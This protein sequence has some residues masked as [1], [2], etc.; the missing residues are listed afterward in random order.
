M[1]YSSSLLIVALIAFAGWKLNVG[2]KTAREGTE[3]SGPQASAVVQPV[4][5]VEKAYWVPGVS[6][7]FEAGFQ[8]SYTGVNLRHFTFTDRK[9]SSISGQ[10]HERSVSTS[11]SFSVLHNASARKDRFA[12]AG[13]AD[14]GALIVECWTLVPVMV[15]VNLPNGGTAQAEAVDSNGMTIK[16]L[17]KLEVFRGGLGS[18]ILGFEY[19]ADGRFVLLL[20]ADQGVHRLYSIESSAGATP[21]ELFNSNLVAGLEN[22]KHLAVFGH[23]VVNRI[24]CFENELVNSTSA[25][26]FVDGDNDG[27]P[28]GGPYSGDWTYFASIGLVMDENWF[29]FHHP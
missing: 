24:W 3:A 14:G 15:T 10:W 1:K 7:W 5:E 13:F 20:V 29:A 16:R 26:M 8:Q 17:D 4:A 19:D 25:I 27:V 6:T 2:E 9:L 12:V 22:M 28:D 23:T 11:T 21:Q 18:E